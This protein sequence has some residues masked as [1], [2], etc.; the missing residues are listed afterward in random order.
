MGNQA[1]RAI[2]FIEAIGLLDIELHQIALNRIESH[3]IEQ[4]RDHSDHSIDC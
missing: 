3:R 4:Y 2:A 1:S